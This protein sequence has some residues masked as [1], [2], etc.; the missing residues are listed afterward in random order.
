[1]NSPSKNRF[2]FYITILI[3]IISCA[4]EDKQNPR[5]LIGVTTSYLEC[6]V[7]DIAG[8][9]FD[10]VRIAPPG[11][12]PGHFDLTPSLI[13]NLKKCP[14]IFRFD[15]QAS[16]DDKIRHW[17]KNSQNIYSIGAPEGL[18]IPDS[19]RSCL[20]KAYE[21]LCKS[22]P[23]SIS[24]FDSNLRQSF[25][26]LDSLEKEC[27]KFIQEQEL[28][29]IKVIASGHQD[30]FC[31]WLGLNVLA[32]YSGGQ[33]TSPNQLK[34][35]LDKGKTS[36]VQLIVANLQEGRQQAEALSMHLDAPF[37]IFSNFPNMGSSQNS[38]ESLVRSN[39]NEFMNAMQKK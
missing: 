34:E 9:R 22:F 35:I 17:N 15:F 8:D 25:T 38:F 13:Q 5:I 36:G 33:A 6:A 26:R 2:L 18:C 20:K 31:R 16:L 30:H 11:M 21:A 28:T 12:C 29:G 39:L 7:R 37:A 23:A 1:M 27:Q 32:S 19:Y 10:Y 14:V 3:F 24:L 4:K